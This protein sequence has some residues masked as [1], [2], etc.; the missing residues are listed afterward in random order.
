MWL[1]FAALGR[2]DVEKALLLSLE[3]LFAA[4]ISNKQVTP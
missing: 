1:L 2:A 4:K 3:M